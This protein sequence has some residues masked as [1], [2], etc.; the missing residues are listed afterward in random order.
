MF[1]ATFEKNIKKSKL[2]TIDL[3]FLLWTPF[4]LV[5]SVVVL[6]VKGATL[7]YLLALLSPMIVLLFG[8][9]NNR[10]N[11]LKLVIAID[12]IVYHNEGATIGANNKSEL[13]DILSLRNRIK[14][15]KK[16]LKNRLGLFIL[17]L[18]RIKRRQFSRALK[19]IEILYE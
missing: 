1:I 12:S 3:Y 7:G 6:P 4:M 2:P 11:N 8:E 10:N 15:S 14:F 9:K 17:F 19:V 5:Q 16:Y 18:I 13:G